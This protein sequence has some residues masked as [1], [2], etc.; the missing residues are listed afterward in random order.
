MAQSAL[1]SSTCPTLATSQ[2]L[3]GRTRKRMTHGM[4]LTRPHDLALPFTPSA[5]TPQAPSIC[6]PCLPPFTVPSM[7]PMIPPDV[8]LRTTAGSAGSAADAPLP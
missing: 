7:R 8:P 2:A 4:G 5:M 6:A 1:V 3:Q